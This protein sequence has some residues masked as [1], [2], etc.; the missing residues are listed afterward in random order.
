MSEESSF[1]LNIDHRITPLNLE[2]QWLPPSK[3]EYM[4][5]LKVT[6]ELQFNIL[7]D[8]ANEQELQTLQAQVP[9][10]IFPENAQVWR[11]H[12]LANGDELRGHFPPDS[13]EQAQKNVGDFFRSL[14]EL[15]SQYD[16]TNGFM[17]H[18]PSIIRGETNE[19]F[20]DMLMK[21]GLGF[22]QVPQETEDDPIILYHP[23]FTSFISSI[24]TNPFVR[25]YS[26]K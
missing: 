2:E 24:R 8:E 3:D 9:D 20:R 23:D 26:S 17:G 7:S 14:G 4:K 6:R 1:G 5:D 25:R 18:A 15:K 16:N 13:P 12:F 21:S 22:K 11:M 10:E 19:S